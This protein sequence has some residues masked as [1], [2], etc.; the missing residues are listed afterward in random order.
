MKIALFVLI[1]L[2]AIP[3]M[4]A[5][6]PDSR[7][8]ITIMFH[9]YP[10]SGKVSLKSAAAHT[11]TQDYSSGYSGFS[12]QLCLPLDPDITFLFDFDIRHGKVDWEAIDPFYG[13]SVKGT[14]YKFGFGVRLYIGESINK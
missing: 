8:S 3:V 14:D 6:N 4:A 13:Q 2:L 10:S 5:E 12:S 11:V 9:T 1:L 7:P